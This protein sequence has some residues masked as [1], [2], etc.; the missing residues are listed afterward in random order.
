LH[1]GQ[2]YVKESHRPV[3]KR[4]GPKCYWNLFWGGE[5]IGLFISRL[6]GPKYATTIVGG[7]ARKSIRDGTGNREASLALPL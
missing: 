7:G 2:V 1:V 4:M 3:G 6:L 5:C